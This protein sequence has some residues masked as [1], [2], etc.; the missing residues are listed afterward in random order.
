[1]LADIPG[2][3]VAAHRESGSTMLHIISFPQLEGSLDITWFAAVDGPL[4]ECCD[5]HHLLDHVADVLRRY[6]ER[7]N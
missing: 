3:E 4:E 5:F 2:I 6:I 1:M 7:R